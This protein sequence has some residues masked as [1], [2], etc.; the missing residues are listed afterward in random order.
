VPCSTGPGLAYQPDAGQAAELP[1]ETVA[2]RL[3]T[4]GRFGIEIRGQALI[5]IGKSQKRPLSLL[6]SVI[7]RG[8][9]AV[10][11]VQLWESLW[12]D[13][14]GDLAARNLTITLHRLRH[15]LAG[16]AAILHHEGKLSLNPRTCW[17]DV[18]QFE[19]LVNDSLA[20]RDSH[21]RGADWE[22]RLREAM[23]LYQGHFL[24]L[25]AE[26]AWMIEPRM[27]W[28]TRFERVASALTS[29]LEC[30]GRFE[31][32]IDVC[33]QAR[34]IDPLNELLYRR[35]MNC[36]LKLGETASV[37]RV[38]ADCRDALGRGLAMEPSTETERLY[39]LATGAGLRMP[40]C[41]IQP[42][43]PATI[44]RASLRSAPLA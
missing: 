8:G 43:R 40:Q 9:Q 30:E 19:R 5:A 24:A 10:S 15:L 14:D 41:Q 20:S 22:A 13:S 35:A 44:T 2:V 11:C 32:A 3:H 7:A 6:Q 38:Y 33:L 34:E 21:L 25:E 31:E 36:Y 29:Y 27:R 1:A 26:E 18:W 17:V 42:A 39:R 37:A 16:N 28:K 4:L 12:P 23:G